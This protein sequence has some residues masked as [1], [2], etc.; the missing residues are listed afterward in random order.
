MMRKKK[1][2]CKTELNII[3]EIFYSNKIP[4]RNLNQQRK[5]TRTS[6]T[7]GIQAANVL[8]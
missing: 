7:Y 6:L 1:Y 3:I 2:L 5:V 4:L 8:D